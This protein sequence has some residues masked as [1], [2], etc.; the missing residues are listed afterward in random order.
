MPQPKPKPHPHPA[1]KSKPHE[2]AT[3]HRPQERAKAAARPEKA[4]K[5]EP[6]RKTAQK[7]AGR[8][9]A[10]KPEK[11]DRVVHA[12]RAPKAEVHAASTKWYR[13][14]ASY[15]TGSGG[16][17]CGN[18]Q[19]GHLHFAE[20]GVAGDYGHG[21]ARGR[22][23]MAIDL[24]L[25]AQLRCGAAGW[26][27]YKG[28]TTYASK[29]DVGYGNTSLP[30]NANNQRRIDLYINLARYLHFSGVDYIEFAP[31][32]K[33]H[34]GSNVPQ[35]VA[36]EWI[37]PLE[38]AHV[39]PERIDQGVD[40]AGTGYLVAVTHATVTR[41]AMGASSGWPGN[42]IEYQITT[43]GQLKGA[44]VYYAEGVTP[45][46]RVGQ[47]LAPGQKVAT[48]IPGWHSGIECGFGSGAGTSTYY[49]YHDGAYRDGTATRPGLAW[50][51]LVRRLGGP[52]GIIEGQ[53][54]GKYPE[55]FHNGTL[56][57][58]ITKQTVGG[59]TAGNSLGPGMQHE[60]ASGYDWGVYV[61]R[62]WR[63]LDDGAK[64]GA[65]YAGAAREF[66]VKHTH[67]TKSK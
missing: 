8:A 48:L 23:N 50:D 32:F 56:T 41:I 30:P 39:R 53:V 14:L 55:Y 59:L 63:N 54:V 45:N 25:P 7:G 52:G 33:T 2:K 26:I 51:V 61:K 66:A 15:Y 9:T 57:G 60:T 10:H 43:P 44:Y 16:G 13:M 46:V 6:A 27:R 20:L 67:L 47:V 62:N 11:A 5:V 12:H 49:G 42:F 24:G 29:A 22:G 19:D 17:S 36:R 31:N 65:G 4:R 37:N 58:E 18:L 64:A 35:R 38:H 28:R 40:Y 3:P 21:V 34:T 1:L